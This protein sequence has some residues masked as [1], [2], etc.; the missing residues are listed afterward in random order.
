MEF[1]LIVA[2]GDLTDVF[3]PRLSS[4]LLTGRNLFDTSG[5]SVFWVDK[6]RE[7]NAAILNRV[8]INANRC[9]NTGESA[10]ITHIVIKRFDESFDS[11]I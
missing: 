4:P 1:H 9:D 5:D 10:R 6:P 2:G 3:V 7:H 11:E 8:S